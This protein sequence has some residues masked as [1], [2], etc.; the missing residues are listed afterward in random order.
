MNTTDTTTHT[1]TDTLQEPVC[2]GLD[3]SR[4]TLDT[5]LL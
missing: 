2:I 5:C 1:S 4:D 3:V